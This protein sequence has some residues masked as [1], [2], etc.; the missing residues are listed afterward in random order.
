[1]FVALMLV[2]LMLVALMHRHGWS[3]DDAYTAV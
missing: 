3:A 2:A 1:M